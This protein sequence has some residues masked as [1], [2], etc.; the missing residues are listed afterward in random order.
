MLV[1][2]VGAPAVIRTVMLNSAAVMESLNKICARQLNASESEA[3]RQSTDNYTY[4]L[5][6]RLMF[7]N[8]VNINNLVQF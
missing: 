3:N 7:H 2:A 8:Q 1:T 4:S 5:L 6:N